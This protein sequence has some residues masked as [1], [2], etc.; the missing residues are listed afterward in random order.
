VR[1]LRLMKV[2]WRVRMGAIVTVDA[3]GGNADR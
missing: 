1:D 2:A 3:P